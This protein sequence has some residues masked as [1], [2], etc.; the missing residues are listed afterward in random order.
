MVTDLRTLGVSQRLAVS[1]SQPGDSQPILL[2]K[3]H[4]VATLEVLDNAITALRDCCV[5]G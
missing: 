1:P 5:T 4:C 2:R 3:P